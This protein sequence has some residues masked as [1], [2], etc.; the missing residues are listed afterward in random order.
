[1]KVLLDKKKCDVNAARQGDGCTPLHVAAALGHL[2][3]AGHLL[4]HGA[5]V[6]SK[7]TT[8]ESHHPVVD[9]LLRHGGHTSGGVHHRAACLIQ[10]VWRFHVHKVRY[11]RHGLLTI[12]LIHRL[13]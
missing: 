6:N 1:M 13:P 2:Q 9:P 12:G 5:P 4:Q 3:C 11:T 7:D 8:V 10:A